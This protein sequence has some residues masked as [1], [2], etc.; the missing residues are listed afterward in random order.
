MFFFSQLINGLQLGS[1]YALVALGYTM[2]YGI[3]KLLNFAHG[4]IIMVGG[5]FA[6]MSLS[7]NHL[8][9]P[10]VIAA[11]I[12]V[13]GC[14]VLAVVIEKL[15]YAPLRSA[16]RL[17]ILIT[18]IGISL[19][20]QNLAQLIFGATPQN[21]PAT[22]LIPQGS[23]MLGEVR[24]GYT[25]LVTILTAVISMII[26]TILVQKTKL[27]KAMRAVSED[28][29]AAR[30][31]G[32]NVNTVVTFT[33]AVGAALAGVG[34]L[35]YSAGYPRLEPTMGVMLGLVA[36]IAAVVGGIGSIPGAM[37]GGFA[38]G[39]VEVF[40]T[41]L[42]YSEWRIGAVFLILIIVLMVRPTGIMGRNLMEKV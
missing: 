38:I 42:G 21:F 37:I 34:A 40:V 2:V 22:L 6:L 29:D 15:A 11:I 20:L 16:P 33:F 31:M 35:L 1:I 7:A 18:A 39:L 36:F 12:T 27:G 32:I 17:S 28:M 25:P 9:L 23:I 41:A 13:V 4:D 26:L 14:V 30:L 8:G 24:V 19:L 10:P 3:V 5:Y